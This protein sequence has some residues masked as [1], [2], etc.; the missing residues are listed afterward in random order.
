[1]KRR[2]SDEEEEDGGGGS[3]SSENKDDMIKRSCYYAITDFRMKDELLHFI[4]MLLLK[5]MVNQV[6]VITRLKLF[7]SNNHKL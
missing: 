4:K 6:G 3:S 5:I 1:M 2:R 7:Q